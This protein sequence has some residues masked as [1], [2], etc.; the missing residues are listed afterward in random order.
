M[1][2]CLHERQS[3]LHTTSHTEPWNDIDPRT[4]RIEGDTNELP[5]TSKPIICS[6]EHLNNTGKAR[7]GEG[8]RH[9]ALFERYDGR[10]GNGDGHLG[11]MV[12]YAYF[13]K[14]VAIRHQFET[15]NDLNSQRLLVWVVPIYGVSSDR[16]VS[17]P[18]LRARGIADA[19]LRKWV[20]H[21][22]FN[23]DFESV[24]WVGGVVPSNLIRSM[25]SL[26]TEVVSFHLDL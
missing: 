11:W 23:W 16:K 3:R 24:L 6:V 8:S 15:S 12:D 9:V 13:V 21:G 22:D 20:N 25:T 1:S 4:C 18:E 17:V 10:V 7:H 26:A 2:R 14:T 5:Q 19:I